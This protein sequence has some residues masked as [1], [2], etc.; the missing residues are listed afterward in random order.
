MGDREPA[1]PAGPTSEQPRGQSTEE[2]TGR[3]RN[4][5][6]QPPGSAAFLRTCSHEGPA[7]QGLPYSQ[8]LGTPH[9]QG[10]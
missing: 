1:E 5:L 6:P 10:S 4:S 7:R 3:F 9:T 8:S 2:H